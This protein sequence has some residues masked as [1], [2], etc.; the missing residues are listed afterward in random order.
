[1]FKRE[2]FTEDSVPEISIL[3]DM[4]SLKLSL[5]VTIQNLNRILQFES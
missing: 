2:L 4:V 3:S 5:T 1:M